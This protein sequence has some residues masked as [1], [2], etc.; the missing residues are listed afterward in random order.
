MDVLP[1]TT[2]D[3][4]FFRNNELEQKGTKLG[5]AMKDRMT[6]VDRFKEEEE[7]EE[8]ERET[9]ENIIVINDDNPL[10][11]PEYFQKYVQRSSAKYDAKCFKFN[12]CCQLIQEEELKPLGWS[13][14]LI[15]NYD[16][17]NFE[18]E[19]ICYLFI[20]LFICFFF[21]H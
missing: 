21:P 18:G 7:E 16:E 14:A 8:D 12:A 5:D 11:Y 19:I 17:N 4:S 20:Y 9:T 3:P 6:L 15:A 1:A 13:S 10:E 2:M